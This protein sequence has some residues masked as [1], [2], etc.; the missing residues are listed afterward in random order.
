MP[1][2]I[3]VVDDEQ[4]VRGFC[5]AALKRFGYEAEMV[6]SGAEALALMQ[7]ES[8]DLMLT[9]VMMPGMSGTD[10]I[11][12]VKEVA[13]EISAVVMTG[14]STIDTA[15]KALRSG[16]IDFIT[17]PF[18]IFDLREA[19][20][21]AVERSHMADDAARTRV[22][23]PLFEISKN[24]MVED[25]RQAI[26]RRITDVAVSQMQVD[27]AALVMSGALP[28]S[29][30][31]SAQGI[32]PDMSAGSAPF[33]SAMETIT[34]PVV[35]GTEDAPMPELGAAMAAA[36]IDW[37]LCSPLRTATAYLGVLVLSRVTGR[38]R[39]RGG[40]IESAFVI[41]SQVAALLENRRL[42]ERLQTLNRDLEDRVQERTRELTTAHN[43]LLR[44]ERLA[45]VGK[46]G[47]G[48]AHELRNPLGVISNSVY[49][50]RTRVG[51]D[52]PKVSKHLNI[53]SRE[54]DAANQIITDLMNFVRVT[55]LN[56]QSE[57][58][59]ALIERSIERAI[60]PDDVKVE[61][62]IAP[63]LPRIT[64]DGPKMEQVCLNLITNA[65]Q[66]MTNGGRLIISVIR[67]DD[68]IVFRFADNGPG[69]PPENL[70]SIFEPLF[71]TKAKG[72]GLGLS[73]VKL[74]VEAQHGRVS[75]HSELGK[76]ACFEVSLP[77]AVEETDESEVA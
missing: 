59:G 19:V 45:T 60:I 77:I 50:L 34:E 9:D 53:I 76:G 11:A 5:T 2:R 37:L 15:V 17:K 14:Y 8:F 42:I 43:R 52:D 63:D 3:L 33:L 68:D 30:S 69:I 66:A 73:L 6:G 35:Y 31:S 21:H 41:G 24:A 28:S 65:I 70:E 72:I 40:D 18:N 64:A 12:R 57:D 10:L 7:H 47:A 32:M 71:T 55:D 62:E 23:M 20:A 29:C 27:G 46:L 1:E 49:Y 36:G 67:Q 44:A 38:P 75:V 56:A 54:V 13:P 58:P 25:D 74:L 61:A 39:F 22:L 51:E 16:A 26:C 48:V 4:E